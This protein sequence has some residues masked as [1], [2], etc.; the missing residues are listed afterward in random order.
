MH[1]GARLF[2]AC[3]SSA[4]MRVERE[5]GAAAGLVGILAA[6]S[7]QGHGRLH[8][9]TCGP[10]GD[11]FRACCSWRSEGL[12]GQSFSIAPPSQALRGLPCLG[13]FSVVQ[14]IRHIE[15][16]PHPPARVLLCRSARQALK[17]APWVGSCSVVQYIRHLM[18]RP[19]YCS[20]VDAGEWGER[21]W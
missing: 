13:F 3:G 9:R 10:V 19:L 17:G 16:H 14:H 2:F 4:P 15:P 11:F 21:L 8:R 7:V 12:F 6:P 20:A 18:G 5:G 1:T